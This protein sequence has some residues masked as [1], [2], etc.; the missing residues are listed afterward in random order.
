[1]FLVFIFSSTQTMVCLTI[2]SQYA[3]QIDSRTSQKNFYLLVHCLP[4]NSEALTRSN[5]PTFIF[6]IFSGALFGAMLTLHVKDE[7][8][9]NILHSWILLQAAKP[10]LHQEN[11]TLLERHNKIK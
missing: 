5:C 2:F 8:A 7:N 1:M 4:L 9:K 6:H 3:F 10:H 11:A